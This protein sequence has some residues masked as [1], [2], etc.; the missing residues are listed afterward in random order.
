[1]DKSEVSRP[2]IITLDG[3]NY[4]PWSQAI[5][6]FLKGRKLWRY[7]TGDITAPTQG[8]AE[9]PTEFIIYTTAD[10][11]CQYQLMTSLCRQRQEPGQ[12]ISAFLPQIYFIWDQ[13][14]PFEPKWLCAGDS[15]LFATYRDQQRLILF[16]MGL[17][18]I[19]EPVRASLLHRIPLPT[20]EQ[21]ISE[22]LSEETRLGLVSTSHVATA[23]AT[24][25]SRPNECTF[26]H[27]TDHRLLTCP[28]RVC[29]TCH[30]RGPGHYRSDCPNNPTRQ[31]TRPQ[32]T[33]ATAG[34][35]STASA[36]PTLIDVNDLPA[37]VQQIMC[38]NHMTADLFVFSSKSYE[39]SFP[40]V[41]TI[42]GSSMTVDHVGHVSTSALSLPNTYY[43][44]NLALN[45]ISVGQLCD[46]GLTV[47]FSSTGCVVQDPRTGQTLGIGRRHGRL[48]QLIH[49]HLPISTVA[50]TST[51]SPS[52]SF[53][54]WHSRLGHVSLGRLRFLVSKGVLVLVSS[55]PFALVHSDIWGPSPTSTMGG[56]QYFVI[57][58][59]DF[60]RYTWLYLLKNR[61]QLQQT[62]YDFARMIKTQFSR[63]IQVFCSDNAQEYC[64]TSFLAFLREQG[65]LPHRSCPGTSQQNG[66]AERKHRH[67]LD[68]TRALLIS[69]G[70]PERFWGEAALAAAYTINRV[71][72]PLLGNLTPYERLYGTPPDYHSLRVFGCACFVLLQP[73]EQTKLEPRSR[74]CC[75]LGYGIEHKGYR[76]WDPLSRRL[77]VSRHVVFWEHKMFSSL[78]SFQM[79]SSSTPPYLTDPSI[80]LFP[81]D[82]DVP[83]D[84]PDD[85]LHV[86]LPP[87]VY[88][89]E[90]SST[91][92]AP[93]V[94]PPVPLPS[95]IPVCRSTRQAMTEELQALDRTHTWDLVD[96]P[97]GKSIIGCRWVYKIKTRADGTVERYKLVWLLRV[98]L[99]SLL[100][101]LPLFR[102]FLLLLLLVLPPGSSSSS[103]QSAHGIVLLLLYVDDM[104]ITGDDVHG[105]SELQDFLHRHF[106]MKDLGPLSYFLGL[107]VSSGST[108][109]SLTQ[110][111]YASDLLTRAGLSDCKTASTPLEANARL[112]SLDGDLL[113]DATLYR[114]L[115]GSLIYLTVTRPDI[116]H[117]VHL[118]SQF[119]S[120]PRSTHYAA[121]LRILR[122]V[123][124]TLFHGLHFYSQSSLQL[125]AYSDADWAGDPTDRRSTTSF[126]FFLGDSLIS[127]RRA[128]LASMAS[129]GHGRQSFWGY[130]TSLT[131]HLLPVSSA[132]QTADIFTKSLLPGRFDALV[133]KL[134]LLTHL[135]PSG[136][137]PM[138]IATIPSVAHNARLPFSNQLI[139]FPTP[140]A[141]P[142]SLVSL[143][144]QQPI[145]IF[146]ISIVVVIVIV[147]HNNIGDA[148]RPCGLN[149]ENLADETM[150]TTGQQLNPKRR[151]WKRSDSRSKGSTLGTCG[152]FRLRQRGRSYEIR[153]RIGWK[154]AR[155]S[156]G[157][158][159]K[160]SETLRV[161]RLPRRTGGSGTTPSSPSSSRRASPATDSTR[162]TLRRRRGRQTR[163][164]STSDSESI[165]S[166]MF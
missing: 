52:P 29:K 60:S 63:D 140:A 89:V 40:I 49:L 130:C 87:I 8:A 54:I 65:T 64:D 119:M 164:L 59:D 70:C 131:V 46:L 113:S 62:Y 116:A 74:L 83:A 136:I 88:P 47:L 166:L 147:I 126:C 115:V 15:T 58:V 76:C 105:I 100:P 38:S 163:H 148:R 132:D 39:S 61:S 104:I 94:L 3:P 114:Q 121:V 20:L 2:I 162:R 160:S 144:Q 41:H 157:R 111:K 99:K 155:E 33:A 13:L 107:E 23:L 32:S 12:S 149:L 35:S 7:V 4:I 9:T 158:R 57:F 48:F 117:V 141:K 97:P 36:S 55:V 122:Y 53:G 96:L 43:V 18:D 50:A 151:R 120:A 22:L 81:E 79:S 145:T 123:K 93:P 45:L 85:T 25:A 56:S 129:L 139:T 21:A 103:N 154:R 153:R 112:T 86:A 16:L 44:R 42:D 127:W 165:F 75:F 102:V 82:V 91:D 34:V 14:A 135:R 134:K 108:G 84:P 24:P 109:Y 19:Y 110:T 11:A 124:G 68:T 26:C 78:S 95:D 143:P 30:Q 98:L 66:R 27:A 159:W 118:V 37:L 71:P 17:S 80:D 125:Y 146:L 156:G 51:S 142:L 161:R 106:E 150:K 5:S 77:R 31:D 72:S 128:P 73:H 92:P 6:S 138:T 137:E 10:L 1:M 28:I 69:S 133:T 152:V 67:L 101:D 90:S